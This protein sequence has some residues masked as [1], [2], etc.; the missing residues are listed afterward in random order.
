MLFKVVVW[1]GSLHTG[2]LQG[3]VVERGGAHR[4]QR[5]SARQC[6]RAGRTPA[7]R[8][9]H[10]GGGHRR[11]RE[12]TARLQTLPRGS[13]VITSVVSQAELLA[14]IYQAPREQRQQE[15]RSLYEHLLLN[16]LH[17]RQDALAVTLAIRIFSTSEVFR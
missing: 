9:G 5:H 11:P 16:I 10:A 3:E 17:E 13:E 2:M 12:Q 14:G 8:G 1:R 15:L 6:D 7:V 4:M